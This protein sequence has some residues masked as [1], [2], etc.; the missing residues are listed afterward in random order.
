MMMLESDHQDRQDNLEHME[1]KGEAKMKLAT[2]TE[3]AFN[4]CNLIGQDCDI[5]EVMLQYKAI[6]EL[7]ADQFD[8]LYDELADRLGFH[9]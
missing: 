2:A 7:P 1:L 9:W 4:K 5:I 6:R 8:D 3:K